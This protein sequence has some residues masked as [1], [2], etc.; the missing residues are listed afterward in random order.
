MAEHDKEYSEEQKTELFSAE[1][2][3]KFLVQSEVAVHRIFTEIKR[4]RDIVTGYFN[5]GRQHILTAVLGV[6]PDH[7]RL[8]L[9]YSQDEKLNQQVLEY[10]RL[11]CTTRHDRIRIKFTCEG[12]QLA[13]YQDQKALSCPIP[14][15]LYRLQRREFFRVDMPVSQPVICRIPQAGNDPLELPVIDMSVG[16]LRLQTE[17]LGFKPEL[18][19][20]LTGCGIELPELGFIAIDLEVRNTMDRTLV[21]GRQVRH[22]GCAFA[23][24]GMEKNVTIQR[25]L[26][27]IQ[28]EQKAMAVND[29]RS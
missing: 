24:L 4:D 14:K 7:D 3:D 2:Q 21:D 20:I 26:H 5:N 25:F 22:I 18:K 28:V 9:D 19:E 27:K 1:D 15:S 11:V 16:G 6:L 12:I 29:N 10:G 13:K 17:I 8:V 23:G